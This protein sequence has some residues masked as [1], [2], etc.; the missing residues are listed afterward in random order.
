VV[1]GSGF[2]E[3]KPKA[4]SV[5]FLRTKDREFLDDTAVNNRTCKRSPGCKKKPIDDKSN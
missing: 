5:N 2:V 1:D 4:E 3:T